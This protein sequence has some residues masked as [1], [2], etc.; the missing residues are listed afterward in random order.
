MNF[1]DSMNKDPASLQPFLVF[2]SINKEV[3]PAPATSGMEMVADK[4]GRKHVGSEFAQKLNLHLG[5]RLVLNQSSKWYDFSFKIGLVAQLVG[6]R[7]IS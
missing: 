5:R 4:Y 6:C 2:G 3:V 7:G 1:L